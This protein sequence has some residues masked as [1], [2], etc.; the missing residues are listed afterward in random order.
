[1]DSE[2]NQNVNSTEENIHNQ[3]DKQRH[4]EAEAQD[5]QKDSESNKNINSSGENKINQQDK[6]RDEEAEALDLY[7]FELMK[8]F[9][10][11]V[12]MG[13]LVK[14]GEDYHWNLDGDKSKDQS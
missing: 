12:N 4:D 5:K 6:H 2:S 10:R 7:I 3:Q 1:M 9:R 13:F 11:G 8:M 14:Q